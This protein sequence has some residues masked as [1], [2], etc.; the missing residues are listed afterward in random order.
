MI[1]RELEYM[2][3]L[4]RFGIKPGLEVMEQIMEGL[5]HPERDYKVV[6]IAGT[7]GKGSTASFVSSVLQTQGYAVGLY[8]SPHLRVGNERIQI[9]GVQ[10]SDVELSVLV[11]EIR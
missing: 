6:H 4:E 5:G 11:K 10:I 7:N 9:S 1:Q 8:T 3:A 2:Y